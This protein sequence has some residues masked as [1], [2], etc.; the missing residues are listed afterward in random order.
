MTDLAKSIDL[1]LSEKLEDPDYREQFFLA[2]SSAAIAS[3]L[4]A[5]RKRRGL[6]QKQVAELTNTQQPAISR[7]ER[8]DYQNWSFNILRRIAN[9]LGARIRVRIEPYEDV[10]GEYVEYSNSAPQDSTNW[11]AVNYLPTVAGDWPAT[12]AGPSVIGTDST[13][14]TTAN[15]YS[16]SSTSLA[17]LTNSIIHGGIASDITPSAANAGLLHHP[18]ASPRDLS[19]G[20]QTSSAPQ[21]GPTRQISYYNRPNEPGQPMGTGS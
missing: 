15:G 13:Y 1:K 21:P 8:A 18:F 14:L 19:Q 16:A 2:E 11:V 6:S 12:V 20:Q 7:T 3:Q 5:L 10:L 17:I 9:A 4:I